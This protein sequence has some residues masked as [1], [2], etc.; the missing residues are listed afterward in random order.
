MRIEK[1]KC[2]EENKIDDGKRYLSIHPDFPVADQHDALFVKVLA[3]DSG[4]CYNLITSGTKSIISN[5]NS[6]SKAVFAFPMDVPSF[7]SL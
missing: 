4:S 1:H 5:M 3:I 2:I 6:T 7:K